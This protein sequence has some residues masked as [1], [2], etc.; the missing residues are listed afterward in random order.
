MIDNK[1][2]SD[3]KLQR[4]LSLSDLV[5]YG[6]ILIQPVA[7][8]PLFG[9]ANNISKGHAVTTILI[10]MAAMILTAISYGRM[11]TRYPAAGSA[12]TYVG[13][14]IHP[15]VGFIAGWSMF[16]DYMFI[17]ILCVIFTSVTAAHMLPFIPYHFWIFFFAAGF[18]LLN[19]K[20]ECEL[21]E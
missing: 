21:K 1:N 4:V 14:G 16:M 12:Y 10:A 8:L 3:G 15:H 11:A 6:I 17:P 19:L 13:K 2:S 5:I 7:A 18:T 9:H 20:G